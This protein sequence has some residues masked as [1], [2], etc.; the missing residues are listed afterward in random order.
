MVNRLEPHLG[1]PEP[2]AYGY[3]SWYFMTPV[4]ERIFRGDLEKYG[5]G[6]GGHYEGTCDFGYE[7]PPFKV[8]TGALAESWEVTADKIVLHIRP[9]VY[10]SGISP[11]PVMESREYTAHDYV[12]NL[13]RRLGMAG[14]SFTIGADFIKTPYEEAIYAEDRYTV[15]IETAHFNPTWWFDLISVLGFQM[16]PESVEAGPGVWENIV[17]TGAFTIKEV[18]PGSH[19][20][21]GRHPNY[22]RTTTING[23]EYQLPFLDGL[24]L[25]V[26]DDQDTAVAA[27][28]TGKFD[29]FLFADFIYADSLA[30]TT[31]ELLMTEQVISGL[32]PFDMRV[33]IPPF[34]KKE[35]RRALFLG[36]DWESINRVAMG[37]E[38]GHQ[39]PL[40]PLT[41]GYVPIEELPPETRLLFDYNPD[42]AKQMLAEAGYPDGFKARVVVPRRPL[43]PDLVEM[44]AGIWLEDFGIELELDVVDLPLF[45]LTM[46]KLLHHAGLNYSANHLGL[47]NLRSAYSST[48]P[49]E[50]ANRNI[51]ANPYFDEL[52][53]KASRAIDTAERVAM[54][55]EAFII[56]LDEALAIPFTFPRKYS[57]WWPW[58]KNYFGEMNVWVHDPPYGMMWLDQDLKAELGY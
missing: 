36:T 9:G 58:V 12:F 14:G 42:L 37:K 26:I 2:A 4:L 55:E 11:N 45:G 51:Y 20:E 23:V 46:D 29:A 41:E 49:G 54:L 16:A 52:V 8:V 35:V 48:E 31:P 19:V 21:Y 30:I 22:W 32:L 33:D 39:W 27:L 7:F 47:T 15:V 40:R 38:V 6:R 44:L 34:D 25:V 1:I 53:D 56:I 28:R 10:F 18:V 17:G 24:T 13:T 50:P 43:L 3:P 57:I 5:V